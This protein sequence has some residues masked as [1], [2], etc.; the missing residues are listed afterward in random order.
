VLSQIVKPLPSSPVAG[1]EAAGSARADREAE[2]SVVGDDEHGAGDQGQGERVAG[3]PVQG[4]E[5]GAVGEAAEL[6]ECREA[7][8]RFHEQP[9]RAAQGSVSVGRRPTRA[10]VLRLRCDAGSR[11][12]RGLSHI[13]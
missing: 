8:L 12:G 9:D 10:P 6:V 11:V 1:H 2:V 13:S 5:H 4:A 3:G 7:V